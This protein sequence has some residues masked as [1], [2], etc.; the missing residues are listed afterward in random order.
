MSDTLH[1][2]NPSVVLQDAHPRL[3]SA[4]LLHHVQSAPSVNVQDK[5]FP[6]I[7]Q[8]KFLKQLHSTGYKSS[9]QEHANEKDAFDDDH[10][11]IDWNVTNLEEAG[12]PIFL[13]RSH[14]RI[15]GISPADIAQSI[16]ACM[17]QNSIMAEY[18]NDKVCEI[19]Q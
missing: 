8:S 17:R 12:I 7:P 4:K 18:D 15:D 2:E 6:G 10:S 1:N 11:D 13:E 16:S 5:L 19:C 3:R 14:K 9:Y